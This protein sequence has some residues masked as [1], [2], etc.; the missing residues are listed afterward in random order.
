MVAKVKQSL[1]LY[2]SFEVNYPVYFSN[3]LFCD[4]NVLKRLS[5]L[6]KNKSILIVLDENISKIYG[7]KIKKYFKL[8]SNN[9]YFTTL[10]T[11]EKNKNM[12]SVLKMCDHAKKIGLRRDSIF[13]AIGGGITMDIVGFSAYLYRR[14]IN[15][16]RIPTTLVGMIDAGVGIKVGV[17]FDNSKNFLGGYYAPKA[18]FNAQVFLKTVNEGEIRSG[19]YE[20]LKMAIIRDPSLFETIKNNYANFIQ[21]KLNSKTENAIKI[22]AFLMMDELQGNLYESNLKRKVDFGHT[23]SQFLE[24]ESKFKIPHGQAVGI[25]ILISTHLSLQRK[26]ITKVEFDKIV[27]LIQEIGFSNKYNLPKSTGIYNSLEEIK[28]HR[29]GNLNLVL[30]N[31]IGS[32]VF[33]NSCTLKEIDSARNSLLDM[34]IFK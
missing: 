6:C 32:C 20:M 34:G 18:V 26:L 27:K 1:N 7:Q 11:A 12:S 16:I 19:L 21:K 4:S 10:K 22:S 15:Y 30:P 28:K 5:V 3:N 23:F 13:I 31:K 9:V 29:A 8:I 2:Q 33:T 25:D 17:N 24:I 14:K